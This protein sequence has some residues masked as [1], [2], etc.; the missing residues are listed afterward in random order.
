MLLLMVVVAAAVV[1][2][3]AMHQSHLPPFHQFNPKYHTG[4]RL[5]MPLYPSPTFST[6]LPVFS[7]L[8]ILFV[9]W[10]SFKCSV[11][12]CRPKVLRS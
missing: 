4:P 11:G 10:S 6:A 9:L 7:F 1:V 2:V 5:I 12:D 3:V 8:L